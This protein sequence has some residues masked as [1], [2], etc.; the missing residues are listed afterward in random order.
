MPV[1]LQ[2]VEE[3]A[4]VTGTSNP[5]QLTGAAA[6]RNT[7]AQAILLHPDISDPD[8]VVVEVKVE[9]F[10]TSNFE[11]VEGVYSS[12]ADTVARNKI[13]DSS[14]NGA[15]VNFGSGD[16]V[17]RS[18]VSGLNKRL[19]TLPAVYN[20]T[21]MTG[22]ST[23]TTYINI[24]DPLTVTPIA[25]DA[26]LVC[27]YSSEY[28][29]NR[30]TSGENFRLEHVL[31]YRDGSGTLQEINPS[32]LYGGSLFPADTNM[33]INGAL[34]DQVI[35]NQSNLNASGNWELQPSAK[36]FDAGTSFGFGYARVCYYQ[37]A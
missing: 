5:I 30:A 12:S 20:G 18:G 33:R 22:D 28:R 17:V 4:T 29:A 23:S 1:Q 10:G 19:M 24:C 36:I 25:A 2:N 16:K 21:N 35:L 26:I 8:G 6:N 11:L 15:A 3:N 13:L 32:R 14:N 37:V 9:E 34:S 7:V 31:H 27:F